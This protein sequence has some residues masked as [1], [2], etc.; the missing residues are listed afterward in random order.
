MERHVAKKLL[1]SQFSGRAEKLLVKQSYLLELDGTS[2]SLAAATAAV[3][4]V[5]VIAV[6]ATAAED[7]YE[8]NNPCAAIAVVTKTITHL[9]FL[10]SLYTTY[11]YI[12]ANVL[13]LQ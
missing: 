2:R 4:W 10:L 3:R 1:Q 12:W 5:V 6:V 7:D 9:R 11:Y 8:K 13:Q